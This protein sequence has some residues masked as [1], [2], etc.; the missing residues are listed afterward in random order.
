MS[1]YYLRSLPLILMFFLFF[2]HHLNRIPLAA[3]LFNREVYLEGM[4]RRLKNKNAGSSTVC[5]IQ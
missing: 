2:F 1:T 4:K 3:G 5:C